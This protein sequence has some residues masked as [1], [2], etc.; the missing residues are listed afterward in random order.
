M[1]DLRPALAKSA[2]VAALA[3]SMVGWVYMLLAGAGWVLGI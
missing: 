2:Y 1:N 3:A